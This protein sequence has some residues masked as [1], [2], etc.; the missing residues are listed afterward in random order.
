[1]KTTYLVWK[2][3]SCN[4]INP[5]WLEITGQEYYSLVNSPGSKGRHFIKLESSHES[6]GRIVIEATPAEYVK[7]RKEKDHSD[8]I[9]ESNEEIGYI[10]ISY[11][12][13]ETEDCCHGEELLT[14]PESGF[15]D[16]CIDGI[17]LKS[18]SLAKKT[19]SSAELRLVDMI[20]RDGISLSEVGGLLGMSKQ[21]VFK[22]VSKIL[23]KL[24]DHIG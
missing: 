5:D 19:L 15:E 2:D 13:I 23:K 20:Y 7:W 14:D 24:K 4:G 10:T 8:Y 22:R 21:A 17:L 16:S 1:L 11:H 9:R 3:P 12:A 6:D 18:L